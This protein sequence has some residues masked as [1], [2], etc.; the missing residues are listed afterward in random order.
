[1]SKHFVDLLIVLE[2][3]AEFRINANEASLKVDVLTP[4]LNATSN[5]W[6]SLWI[7]RIGRWLIGH[8]FR[9]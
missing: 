9:R 1:M 7:T 6:K 4:L 8:F 3:L 2:K 5:D